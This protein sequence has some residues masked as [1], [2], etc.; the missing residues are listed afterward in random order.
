MEF[1]N[2]LITFRFDILLIFMAAMINILF[3]IIKLVVL[4]VII[5]RFIDKVFKHLDL[6]SFK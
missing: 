2:V 5:V 1:I 4:G 3:I 6:Y